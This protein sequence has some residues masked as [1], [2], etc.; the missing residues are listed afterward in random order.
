MSQCL[1]LRAV[2]R[3]TA[4]TAESARWSSLAERASRRSA[5]RARRWTRNRA[6]GR[7][8]TISSH[9]RSLADR[10]THIS[11]VPSP[12]LQSDPADRERRSR[13]LLAHRHAAGLL[14][15][16]PAQTVLTGTGEPGRVSGPPA[17]RSA[18]CPGTAGG[19]RMTLPARITATD[20]RVRRRAARPQRAYLT[21]NPGQFRSAGLRSRR[22][23][24][25]RHHS[26]SA[27]CF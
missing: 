27:E 18:S 13:A 11:S 25:R 22:C 21:A 17:G 9:L 4:A 15:S 2:R 8:M 1:A 5:A 10:K 7:A 3:D 20:R 26:T 14:S 24:I 6:S 12:D 16:L 23:S 19:W